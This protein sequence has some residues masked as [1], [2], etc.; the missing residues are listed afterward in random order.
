MYIIPRLERFENYTACLSPRYCV[1]VIDWLKIT[2]KH[3]HVKLT[4][5]HVNS[6]APLSLSIRRT[7]RTRMFAILQNI[8]IFINA[9][10]D[11]SVCYAFTSKPF[12]EI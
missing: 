2:G 5:L 4:T 11:F 7:I 9:T 8:N 12:N 3:M 1:N 6:N 10:V